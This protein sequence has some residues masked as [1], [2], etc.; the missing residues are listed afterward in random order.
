MKFLV[1]KYPMSY[2][3]M[4]FLPW[5]C[6]FSH[7]F[8]YLQVPNFIIWTIAFPWVEAPNFMNL[9]VWKCQISNKFPWL[10]VPNL[11]WISLFGSAKFHMNLPAWKFA[12]SYEHLKFP[13]WKGYISYKFPGLEVPNFRWTNEIAKFH[14][15]F[16][17]WK[18]QIS[19]ISLFGSAQSQLNFPDWKC[20][21]SYEFLCLEVPNFIWTCPLGSSQFLVNTWNS[22]S[23]RAQ[24]WWPAKFAP[25]PGKSDP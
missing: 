2:E 11:K 17:D 13:D 25:W 22:L 21:I 8:P 1:W 7:Q 16:T 3:H 19:W 12:I 6:K 14:L 9:S 23:G 4:N 20:Q 10:E 15:K 18:C 5:K 24:N